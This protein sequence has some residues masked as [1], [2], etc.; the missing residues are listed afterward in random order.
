MAEVKTVKIKHECDDG[1]CV[2]NESDFD[3]KRHTLYSD[4][5][6][7]EAKPKPKKAPAKKATPKK[8]K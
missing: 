2:I 7:P 6:A 1:Y 5:P 4:K 3:D 8:S